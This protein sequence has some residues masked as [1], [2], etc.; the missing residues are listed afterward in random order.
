MGPSF[1][2]VCRGA[3]LRRRV[4]GAV[5]PGLLLPQGGRAA[6]RFVGEGVGEWPRAAVGGGA[7]DEARAAK[8]GRRAAMGGAARGGR[9]TAG[10]RA[11]VTCM[12][13]G[14]R[15]ERARAAGR[16]CS[17]RRRRLAGRRRAAA[18]EETG[19]VPAACAA[20]VRRCGGPAGRVAKTNNTGAAWVQRGCCAGAAALGQGR[21]GWGKVRAAGVRLARCVVGGLPLSMLGGA[22]RLPR[23]SRCGLACVAAGVPVPRALC[24]AS[25]GAWALCC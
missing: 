12:A 16:R 9:T 7:A 21:L 15:G 13:R 10:I 4:G 25:A 18:R 14:R 11:H 8:R 24:L 19:I 6:G 1:A 22:R 3:F 20:G 23:C 5:A 17:E 2:L